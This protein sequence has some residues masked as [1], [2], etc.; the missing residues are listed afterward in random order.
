MDAS[1]PA[2]CGDLVNIP[3][4]PGEIGQAQV[5]RS[6]GRK[7]Q[8]PLRFEMFFTAFDHIQIEIGSLRLRRDSDSKEPAA[9]PGQIATPGQVSRE[10]LGGGG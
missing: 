6:V 10:Q 5:T 2:E 1:V 7:L 3:I 4:R 8:D 9:V